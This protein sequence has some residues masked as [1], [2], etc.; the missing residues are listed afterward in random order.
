MATETLIFNRAAVVSGVERWTHYNAKA[1]FDTGDSSLPANPSLVCGLSSYPEKIKYR[2]LTSIYIYFYIHEVSSFLFGIDLSCLDTPFSED[3]VTYEVL[4]SL[5]YFP[6]ITSPKSNSWESKI[7]YRIDH[8]EYIRKAIENGLVVSLYGAEGSIETPKGTNKPYF[9]FTYGPDNVGLDVTQTYP[10]GIAT[11]SKSLPTTFTWD[12]TPTAI[13]TLAA[14]E[15]LSAVFRWRYAGDTSYTE[16]SC[17]KPTQ[18]TIPGDTFVEGVVEWQIEVTANSGVVTTS[19]WMSTEVKEP[20][21][22]ARALT[23]TNAVLDGTKP[24]TFSWEH[25]IDNGTSQLAFDLQ[26]SSDNINWNTIRY[27]E[28]D[29][30]STEFDANTFKSGAF[31]WRVRT[32]N[33]AGYAGSWSGSAQCIII[34]A[35]EAPVITADDNSPQ[36]ILRWQQSGQQAYELMVDGIVIAKTF[37]AESIYRHDG[38]LN[39]GTHKIQVRIQNCYQLWSE[40][41]FA[42]LNIENVEGAAIQLSANGV[43]EV[44]L[45]WTSFEGYDCYI[46]YR[47]GTKIA[48][49]TNTS[50][51]DYFAIGEAIYWVRGVNA[52]SGYYTLSNAAEVIVLPE[53]LMI[54]DVSKPVWLKLP[55]SASSLRSSSLGASK[56]VA[57]TH[58][59]GQGL[60]NA[61]IGDAINKS[62]DL[63]CAFKATDLEHIRQFEALLGKVVCIKTPSQRRIIGVLAQMTA[64]ENRF[65]VAYTAPIT[66]VKWEEMHHDS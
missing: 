25:I 40:W 1:I 56:S 30:T 41:G 14:V 60:P 37:S 2:E 23:P 22:S 24:Q 39:P 44:D 51:V 63:E 5:H 43:N 46:V 27:V 49:T 36:F 3:A 33:L 20:I 45:K 29:Q 38:Y 61:E 26:V 42:T 34:A 7:L 28:T 11:I 50:Y 12:A 65:F 16:I 47:N 58:Y 6:S 55:L 32:Y 10:M 53:T 64:K 9:E 8:I 21:S 66:E 17:D 52:N 35:P 13:S 57:Y 19:N 18:C 4:G 62:Y 54:A 15:P 31:W 59:V 48:E